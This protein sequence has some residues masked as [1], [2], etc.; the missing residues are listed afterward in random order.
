LLEME[1]RALRSDAEDFRGPGAS[2][3]AWRPQ[4]RVAISLAVV[5]FPA[6][7]C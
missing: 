3:A 1:R 6:G 7:P 5:A 2:G 4:L